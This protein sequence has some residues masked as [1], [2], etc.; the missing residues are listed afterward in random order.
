MNK[1]RE[2]LIKEEQSRKEMEDQQTEILQ[3][4]QKLFDQLQRVSHS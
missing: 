2:K 3:E 4:K 1:I